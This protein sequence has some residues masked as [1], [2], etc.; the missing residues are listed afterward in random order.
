MTGLFITFEGPEGAGK[1]T[2]VTLL[3]EW[4]RARGLE[5]YTTREPGGTPLGREIRRLL[6]SQDM[7]AETEYLLYSADRAEH[8]R[9]VVLPALEEGKIVISDR[10]LDSSLAYQ[11]YGRGLPLDWLRQVAAGAVGSLRPHRTILL[12]LPPEAGLARLEQHDRLEQEHLEFH[13]RVRGGYL[14]LARG[15]PA[16]YLVVDATQ[17]QQAVQAAIQQALLPMIEE[18]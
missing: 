1:S 9:K 18:L 12:D 6:L 13:Q 5:A 8:V 3:A 4:L 16:R 10:H 15:E 2:Q 7:S 11:G 14:Q 17:S